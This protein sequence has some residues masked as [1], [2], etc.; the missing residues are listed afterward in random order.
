MSWMILLDDLNLDEVDFDK[1]G[2]VTEE[3]TDPH[4]KFN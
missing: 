4:I 1:F 3:I 2:E